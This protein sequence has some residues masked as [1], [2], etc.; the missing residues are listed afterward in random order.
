MLSLVF[1]QQRSFLE[2]AL[3]QDIQP[4]TVKVGDLSAPMICT[5]VI[6]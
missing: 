6:W 2:T 4:Q 1:L 5:L 3:P